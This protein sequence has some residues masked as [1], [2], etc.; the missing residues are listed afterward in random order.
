MD[1]FTGHNFYRN[2]TTVDNFWRH[3]SHWLCIKSVNNHCAVTGGYSV[4]PM[5]S[6]PQDINNTN[7]NTNNN[8][9]NNNI[10]NNDPGGANISHRGR[11][12]IW[13][14]RLKDGLVSSVELSCA[15]ISSVSYSKGN[16]ALAAGGSDGLVHVYDVR[17]LDASVPLVVYPS[18]LPS[19]HNS[20]LSTSYVEPPSF[21][22]SR[23]PI[24][25]VHLD[26]TRLLACS[27]N[28]LN[29]FSASP[30]MLGNKYPNHPIP[31]FQKVHSFTAE[32]A[33]SY[34][35]SEIGNIS[36]PQSSAPGLSTGTFELQT[37]AFDKY[38]GT[39]VA[40]SDC[41]LVWKNAEPSSAFQSF[42]I[43]EEFATS[44]SNSSGML[45]Q[46]SLDV[47]SGLP[48]DISAHTTNSR[49]RKEHAYRNPSRHMKGVRT[50]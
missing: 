40:C 37:V 29:V 42:G 43:T 26:T 47:E 24:I 48:G 13:D 16:F 2:N 36:N 46:F 4:I 17:Y 31:F 25:S 18:G 39:A 34:S 6:N 28:A 15:L 30:C 3:G 35:T 41:T 10:R 33:S 49:P 50:R 32:M 22:L 9:N 19:V 5:I 1:T 12:A 20:P 7:T 45:S 27:A 23:A 14:S 21:A 11:L 44:L 8:N 38:T